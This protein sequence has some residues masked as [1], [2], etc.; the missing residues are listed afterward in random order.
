MFQVPLGDRTADDVFAG[1]NQLWRRN[2]RKA[3]KSGVVVELGD[4]DDLDDD[5]A[6]PV[7]A[8][9]RIDAPTALDDDDRS[10]T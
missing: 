3:E 4:Y 9:E 8:P 2:V 6:S 1:F 7:A 10:T 5:T